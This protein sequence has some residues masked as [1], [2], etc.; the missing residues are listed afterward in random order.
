VNPPRPLSVGD[1]VPPIGLPA[2]NGK[3]VDLAHQTI[4]GH[5]MVLW[6]AGAQLDSAGSAQLLETL[7]GL[8]EVEAVAFAVVAATPGPLPAEGVPVLFD[9]ENRVAPAFGLNGPGIV[10]YGADR[11]L[12]AVL[13]DGAWAAALDACRR[14]FADTRPQTVQRQA[15]VLVIPGVIEPALCAALIA[16]WERG[17]KRDDA[18]AAQAARDYV[19]P[20]TKR[21][22]DVG[23]ADPALI[24]T[25][26]DRINRRVVPEVA[27]A[28]RRQVQYLEAF[29]IGC[30]DAGAGGYFRR[31]R[32]NTTRYTAHRLF[33]VTINLNTGQYAGGA[34]RFP[35]YGRMV[36][37]PEAGGAVVFSCALLHEALPV[38]QGRRF[39]VFTFM[40]DEEGERVVQQ[41]IAEEH[42][43]GRA[44]LQPQPAR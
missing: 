14:L 15:P 37:A 21:R 34:L 22:S 9:P 6:L 40:H 20:G 11:R 18:V 44:G 19:D 5:A 42:A 41:L 38:T 30:Y 33:A 7:P 35:E 17:E 2:S 26:H 31:H 4:A 43:A 24:A 23:V 39:G 36:Y 25:L 13:P 32:D 3:I 1:R 10:V 12:A 8:H 28:F 27:K 16:Y 29:R